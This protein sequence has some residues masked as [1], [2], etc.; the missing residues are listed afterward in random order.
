MTGAMEAYREYRKSEQSRVRELM[1][2]VMLSWLKMRWRRHYEF[3]NDD[4]YESEVDGDFTH[5]PESVQEWEDSLPS[6]DGCPTCGYGG[7]EYVIIR[8]TTSA[9]KPAVMKHEISDFGA[10]ITEL[11]GN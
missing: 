4:S 3:H 1:N 6:C 9:G 5:M 7:E 8:F 11:C 10:F 2:D